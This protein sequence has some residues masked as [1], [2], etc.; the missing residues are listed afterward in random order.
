M[1]HPAKYS[2][3][4]LPHFATWLCGYARLLD[5]FAG[6]GKLRTI[7]PDAVLLEIEPE[8]A[9]R[10]QSRRGYTWRAEKVAYRFK[11]LKNRMDES[12]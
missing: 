3:A 5:P 7:R 6:T 10:M 11:M 8:W 12:E 1:N 4:L 9:A 2:D